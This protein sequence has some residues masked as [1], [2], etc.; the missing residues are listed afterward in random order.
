MKF[1]KTVEGYADL[2][3]ATAFYVS[4]DGGKFVVKFNF[5][6]GTGTLP[7]QFTTRAKAEDYLVTVIKKL[8]KEAAN[9]AD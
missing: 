8:N 4:H 6:G 2:G 1:I 7:E 5:N 9:H 3:S